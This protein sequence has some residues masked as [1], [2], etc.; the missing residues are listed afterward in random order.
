LRAAFDWSWSLLGNADKAALA[1]LSVF[2]GGFTLRSAEAVLEQAADAQASW[3]LDS[4]QS[5][6]DKSFVRQSGEHRFDLLGTVQEYA[7]DHLSTADRYPGSG[8]QARAAAHQRHGA[9]FAGLSEKEAIADGCA[10]IDNLV[11]ACR[12]AVARADAAIAVGTLEN[13]WAAL[14]LRGPFRAGADLAASLCAMHGLTPAQLA[15]VE[16]VAGNALDASGQPVEARSHIERALSLARAATDRRSEARAL[17]DLGNLCRNEG[18]IDESLAHTRAGLELACELGERTLECALRNALG[19]LRYETGELEQARVE[20]EAALA[21]ARE[22]G[23][24]RWE[25]G[26]LGN[27]ANLH[28]N[29]G[30][31]DEGRADYEAGLAAAREIGHRQWEG[32]MLCNLGF[33]HLTQQ[34]MD[35]ARANFEAALVAAREMGHARLECIALGNLGIA[36]DALGERPQAAARYEAALGVA[37]RIGERRYEG[38]FLNYLGLLRARTGQLDEARRCLDSSETLLRE[39]SDRISLGVLLCSRAETE[40]LAGAPAAA[41]SALGEARTIASEAG[42]GP[43]SELGQALARVEKL[44]AGAASA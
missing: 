18:R 32:N 2:E 39:V 5:L 27:L 36:L 30:R 38:Q 28:V 31:M 34:R 23:D 41:C 4:I 7:A 37:R 13:A 15:R 44:L 21:L 24:R 26:T 35:E 40:L 22:L 10:E 42:A 6:V 16:R 9:F 3:S 12:R 14:K 25:G 20:Y 43:E 1:Q 33:L 17:G 8:P 11:A 29:L 19:S